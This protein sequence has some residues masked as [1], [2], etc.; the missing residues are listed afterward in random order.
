MNIKTKIKEVLSYEA[1]KKDWRNVHNSKEYKAAEKLGKAVGSPLNK[2]VNCSCLEDLFIV[3]KLMSKD[4]INLKQ[5][6]MESKYELREGVMIWLPGKG[7]H[8]TNANLTD[9]LGKAILKEFPAHKVSFVRMPEGKASNTVTEPVVEPVV[10]EV[11]EPVTEETVEEVVEATATELSLREQA[12][13][14]A[15]ETEGLSKAH[16]KSS[17]ESLKEYIAENSK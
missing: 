8:V 6:Q 1:T 5:N 16:W 4:K 7:I 11:T 2:S 9:K 15:A 12:D 10:E 14:I 13:K 3:I 17:D